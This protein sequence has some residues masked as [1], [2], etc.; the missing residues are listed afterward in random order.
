[1]FDDR[2]PSIYEYVYKWHF[3]ISCLIF[4]SYNCTRI[5]RRTT[6]ANF[7][8]VFGKERTWLLKKLAVAP[9]AHQ[10]LMD[11]CPICDEK[12]NHLDTCS[13]LIGEQ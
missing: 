6:A 5:C 9:A 2:V 12:I 1:M 7:Q 13:S 11:M 8:L 10:S 3:N 4:A